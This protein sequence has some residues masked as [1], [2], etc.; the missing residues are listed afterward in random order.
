[1]KPYIDFCSTLSI[2]LQNKNRVHNKLRKHWGVTT[3]DGVEVFN[4][5]LFL[6]PT[7]LIYR[8]SRLKA[9]RIFNITE[10]DIAGHANDGIEHTF[11]YF[12]PVKINTSSY[13]REGIANLLEER[14]P[15]DEWREFS[16][17][18]TDS[19]NP[20]KFVGYSKEMILEYVK[21]NYQ[22]ASMRVGLS[23]NGKLEGIDEFLGP[24]V[25]QD[26]GVDFIVEVMDAGVT[27]IG[28]KTVDNPYVS[29]SSRY[30]YTQTYQSGIS[31]AYRYK[32]TGHLNDDSPIVSAVLSGL[33]T[34]PL[35]SHSITRNLMR[36]ISSS[37]TD[38]IWY[39]GQLRT[40]IVKK[41]KAQDY[42]K[43]VYGS[44]DIGQILKKPKSS[45]L[46]KVIGVVLAVIVFVV[47]LGTGTPISMTL[48]AMAF[49]AAALMLTVYSMAMTAMGY[50]G[51]GMYI[52]RWAKVVGI[53]ATVLS[54]A[55]AI[56]A[57]AKNVVSNAVKVGA[58]AATAVGTEVATIATTEI[59]L[60]A[61][62]DTAVS[63]IKDGITN[64]SPLS[65]ASA[66]SKVISPLVELR[67]KNKLKD[68]KTV[69][70][71]VRAQESVLADLYDK[72]GHLG[73][74]DIRTYTKPLTTLML[75]YE[76]DWLYEEGPNNILRP[77][78]ARYGMN[79]ISN[80][81]LPITA[82]KGYLSNLI[83]Q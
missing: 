64:A 37:T 77:S 3:V 58:G 10:K 75:Q 41:L 66:T 5:F 17:T 59:T 18:Y 49:T 13:N 29:M 1:M 71:E 34:D 31:V 9:A 56:Q 43:I 52:G 23:T 44:L 83:V 63:M 82:R 14:I 79:I 48:I 35:N 55:S 81:I 6:W 72:N 62:V 4:R 50:P 78:F 65:M 61:V 12:N 76:I 57:F 74:E 30:T 2:E 53:V 42:L 22:Y 16:I 69:Q 51:T 39:K 15:F 80:D 73:L 7:A 47:T 19:E 46:T 20:D 32:R 68:L 27:A 21:D 38:A 67:E 40:D 25:L 24:Y 54:I 8:G 26:N 60:D 70:D 36:K 28:V 11:L 33:V 45:L